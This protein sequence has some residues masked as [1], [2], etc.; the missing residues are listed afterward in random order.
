MNLPEGWRLGRLQNGSKTLFY[1]DTWAD[2]IPVDANFEQNIQKVINNPPARLYPLLYKDGYIKLGDVNNEQGLRNLVK[3]QLVSPEVALNILPCIRPWLV[4]N[5]FITKDKTANQIQVGSTLYIRKNRT[6]YK[7]DKF[8][9]SL[10]VTKKTHFQSVWKARVAFAKGEATWR[11]IAEY[12]W[13]AVLEVICDQ[14]Q[15]LPDYD[16]ETLSQFSAYIHQT[17]DELINEESDI[18][19]F[20]KSKSGVWVPVLKLE[21]L[22]K[23]PN[24]ER[25]FRTLVDRVLNLEISGY[26]A[27]LRFNNAH[28]QAIYYEQRR[29]NQRQSVY[30]PYL[31]HKE[32][33]LDSMTLEQARAYVQEYQLDMI[34][35]G[36]TDPSCVK[37]AFT[38]RGNRYGL[39][40]RS[41]KLFSM[42]SE[43]SKYIP[44]DFDKWDEDRKRE[45]LDIDYDRLCESYCARTRAFRKLYFYLKVCQKLSSK[46]AWEIATRRHRKLSTDFAKRKR[47]AARWNC[48]HANKSAVTMFICLPILAWR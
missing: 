4:R 13:G 14:M 16:N 9:K 39:D 24:R 23:K 25:L 34:T 44:Q 38:Y 6:W 21:D 11:Q 45:Y 42:I 15:L 28:P 31:L 5:K 48:Y 36:I 30:V 8:G 18:A 35:L 43:E 46:K 19:G 32:E 26:G 12:S 17:L 10:P 3:E 22:K 37:T 20:Y 29:W 47:S 7:I 27:R 40:I 41:G 1:K 2:R 33:K